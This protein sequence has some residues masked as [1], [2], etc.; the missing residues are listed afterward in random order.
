M[1][2]QTETS[3]IG[4]CKDE[5]TVEIEQFTLLLDPGD[6]HRTHADADQDKTILLKGL[7]EG[8]ET[9]HYSLKSCDPFLV[10]HP[11]TWS[12]D[13]PSPFWQHDD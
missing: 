13:R 5:L 9:R 10:F 1:A 8:F 12:Q 3:T 2:L 7:I 11:S 6:H 4:K